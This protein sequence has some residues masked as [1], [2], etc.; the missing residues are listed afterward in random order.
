VGD[1]T[2]PVPDPRGTRCPLCGQYPL[3]ADGCIDTYYTGGKLK[4]RRVHRLPYKGEVW[5]GV[6]GTGRCPDVE[7]NAL[8][9]RL[10]HLGCVVELCPVCAKQLLFSCPCTEGT[11]ERYQKAKSKKPKDSDETTTA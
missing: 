6:P 11:K 3:G 4:S 1:T 7:C 9:G 10:H 5:E 2:A 8:I